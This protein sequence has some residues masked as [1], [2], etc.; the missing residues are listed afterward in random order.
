M[1]LIEF[2]ICISTLFM[3]GFA[4]GYAESFAWMCIGFI[5]AVVGL[6]AAVLLLDAR[7]EEEVC[8]LPENK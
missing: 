5:A 7:F 1:K 4:I 8:E 6:L 2:I 3:G